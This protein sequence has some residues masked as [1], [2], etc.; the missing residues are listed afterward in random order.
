V[1][2]TADGGFLIADSLFCDVRKVDSAGIIH[3]VAGTPRTCGYSGDRGPAT[4]ATLNVP[5]RVAATADNGF[6]IADKNN[7]VVRKVDA[8]GRIQTVAGNGTAGYSGDGGPAGSAA[9][10]QP[11]GVAATADNGFLIADH[12]NNV[13]RKVDAAGTIR[14]VAGTGRGGFSGDGGPPTA[15]QL[16]NPAAVAAT[17][18]GGFLIADT[19]NARVRKVT[20]GKGS[21]S[22]PVLSSLRGSPRKQSIVGRKVNG[23][24][25]MASKRNNNRPRCTRRATLT[26]G[27]TI[28]T[29][30]NVK[31]TLRRQITGR[32]VNGKCVR[33]TNKNKNRRKCALL[34]GAGQ[35]IRI[36]KTGTSSFVVTGKFGSKKLIPGSYVLTATPAGGTSRTARF[37]ITG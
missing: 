10:R 13:V 29:A 15:A 3:T 11:W 4:S 37:A 19:L 34:V 5:Y 2:L 35:F 14:T 33:L 8:T 1:A 16:F 12:D 7:N 22:T 25:V 31:F 20:P 27:Y 28:N 9:L 26:I 36:V 6:L 23:K 21:G 18:D 30:G 32:K 17:A 24:C